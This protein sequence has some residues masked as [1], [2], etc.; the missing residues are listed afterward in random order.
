VKSLAI[1]ILIPT[2]QLTKLI[3]YVLSNPAV[4]TGGW[5][6]VEWMNSN[7]AV[8]REVHE[9]ASEKSACGVKVGFDINANASW[10]KHEG[11][12]D[13]SYIDKHQLIDIDVNCQLEADHPGR[14]ALSAIVSVNKFN[15]DLKVEVSFWYPVINL[16]FDLKELDDPKLNLYDIPLSPEFEEGIALGVHY[17]KD[18]YAVCSLK[19]YMD[20]KR[21]V[22]PLI[23]GLFKVCDSNSTEL[24]PNELLLIAHF[25]KKTGK[26][27]FIFLRFTKKRIMPFEICINSDEINVELAHAKWELKLK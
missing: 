7:V 1:K 11:F 5:M 23:V 27:R 17:N 26:K 19:D 21:I 8:V 16:D 25:F 12:T 10:H 22:N 18:C 4:E 15:D 3:D 2:S 20:Y 14:I 13:P 9:R 24:H 6:R